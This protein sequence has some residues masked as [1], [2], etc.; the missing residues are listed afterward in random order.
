MKKGIRYLRFSS[1]GQSQHSI[2]RQDVVTAHW[3][4]F[5]SIHCIDTFT[6]EGYTARTFDRPDIKLLFEF[7]KQHR[8]AID[9]MVVS[10]L[11]RFSREAG[12]AINMVKKIQ[13]QYGIRIVSAGRSAIYDCLDHN[14]FFMM[15]LEFLLGNS[16]N[17][18]R[19]ND[20]LGGIYTAKTQKGKWVRGGAMP[21]GYRREGTDTERRLVQVEE[22]AA[23]VRYIYDAYLANTP[24]YL[25]KQR[26][27]QMGFSR[28]GNSRVHEMLDNPFYMGY[29]YVK[30]WKDQPGGLFPLKNFS[31]IVTAEEW[32]RVQEK[33]MQEDKPRVAVSEDFPLRGV[34]HCHCKK[35]LTGAPSRSRHG[36]YIN[37]YKCQKSGH[38]NINAGKAHVQ[39]EEA[40]SWMSI[41]ERLAIA[42]R[43]KS[44]EILEERTKADSKTLQK[45]RAEL[46]Q[47]QAQITSLEEK[48]LNNQVSVETYHR[49]HSTLSDKR[50][51]ISAQLEKLNRDENELYFLLDEQLLK[52]TDLKA[53]YQGAT[54]LQKQEVLRM[55]FDNRLYYQG[56]CYRTPFLMPVFQHNLLILN[57]KQ[58]LV[59]DG[60]M[61]QIPQGGGHET[62]IEHLTDFLSLVRLIRVA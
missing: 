22:E 61:Q 46:E 25:I 37:Y 26:A 30:S 21:Y 62:S 53:V 36:Y 47:V 3:M 51:V 50:R 39:L 48:F 34:L 57:Q 7:I 44:L 15:G 42:T 54:L 1:D 31:P 8:T 49:W 33:R 59:L 35:M 13:A 45:K 20:I 38:T 6:D 9:Y 17:I 5:N 4:Q 43:K 18:K 2:E 28:K 58:L 32:H 11:T 14:S 12:D 60:Q 10:E 27:E 55:V 19:Q 23:I 24:I 29:Q 41:P 40:L 52:L 56:G 16:E